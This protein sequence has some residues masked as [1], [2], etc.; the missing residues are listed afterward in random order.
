MAGESTGPQR[1]GTDWFAVLALFGCGLAGAMHFAKLSPVMAAVA[2]EFRYDALLSGLAVSILGIVGVIFAIAAGAI[3]AAIGLQRGLMLAMFGGAAAA[4]AAAA[5]PDGASFLVARSIEGFSHLLIVVC[6]PALMAGHASV[7]DKPLVLALWGCFFGLGFAIT[8]AA[9]PAIVAASGWRGLMLTHAGVM[10][11][12]G[13]LALAALA[14]AR[15]RDMRSVFRGWSAVLAA[16]KNVYASGAPLRLALAFCAYTLLFLAV[17]TFL[18]RYLVEGRGWSEDRA[19][20]FIS[21]MSLVSLGGTLSA[22][23]LT[24]LGM[25]FAQGMIL[26][27]ASAAFFSAAVFSLQPGSDATLA[28]AV[29]LMMAAYGFLP[30]FVFS[31]VPAFAPSER[32]AALTYG[33][34]AQFGN[35]GTFA[36]TPAVAQL[37]ALMGWHGASL[38]IVAVAAMGIGLALSLPR[39]IRSA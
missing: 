17:L 25:R 6:A 24:R 13:G 15:H 23:A 30:G 1:A 16:H 20:G 3:V 2:S 21:A 9:A 39:P 7:R 8:S 37:V 29:F 19:G 31:N 26:G 35:V 38:F 27:F 10:A 14:R 36:G 22:G 5:A 11:A 32:E 18:G 12:A 4:V 33:A 34:I 28:V